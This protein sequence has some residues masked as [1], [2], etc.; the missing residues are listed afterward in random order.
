MAHGKEVAFWLKLF[1]KPREQ[2]FRLDRSRM[3]SGPYER[4]SIKNTYDLNRFGPGFTGPD[5]DHV[6][7]IRDEQFSVAD[8]SCPG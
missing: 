5:A 4:E 7:N 3:S 6:Q 1:A 2:R 8:P